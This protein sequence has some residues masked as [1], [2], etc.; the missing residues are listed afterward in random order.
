M[1]IA[2]PMN[3]DLGVFADWQPRVPDSFADSE[4]VFLANIDPEIQLA[5]LRRV[6]AP[7][8]VALDTMNYWIDHKRDALLEVISHVDIVSV[9]ES[10][11][12]QLC[13]TVSV[14][15][16]AR[17]ILARGPRAVVVKR[18]EDGW[19]RLT[20]SFSGRGPAVPL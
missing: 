5:T 12:R 13:D 18:G 11:A 9:N 2:E 1:N 7:K 8:A 17:D 19:G 20:G 16:A 6:R 10:E 4:F 14:A 3:T 15:K